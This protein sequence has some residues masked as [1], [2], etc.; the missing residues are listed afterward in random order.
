MS[1][2]R[3]VVDL[4]GEQAEMLMSVAIGKHLS[5]ELP[6]SVRKMWDRIYDAVK[7]GKA[8]AKSA[9]DARELR[10]RPCSLCG[11]PLIHS[12]RGLGMAPAHDCPHGHACVSQFGCRKC[13]EAR[14]AAKP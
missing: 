1:R 3:V 6:A 2:V 9:H 12:A 11:R 10:R 7:Q 13:T 4:T 8:K 5:D 14:K